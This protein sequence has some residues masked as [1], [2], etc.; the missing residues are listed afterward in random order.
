MSSSDHIAVIFDFDGTL[1]PD[2]VTKLLTAHKIDP[3]KFWLQE[4]RALTDQGYDQV[5][6]YL[7]LILRNIGAGKPLGELTNADLRKFG[8][9]LGFYSCLPRL[10]NDLRAIAKKHTD[11]DVE[12]YVIS[13]GL[14]DII[15]GSKIIR[16]YFR[17]TYGCQLAGDKEDGVLKYIKRAITFTEK[18]R[19]LF[20]INKGIDPSRSLRNSDSVN[21]DIPYEKRRIPFSNMIYIGDGLTDIPCF[22]LVMK[23]LGYHEGGHAFGIF[24]PADEKSARIALEKLLETRRVASTHAHKYGKKDELGSLLRATVKTLCS[25]I[26]SK[27]E[28]PY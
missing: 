14:Q 24:D 5:H 1:V 12:Y 16:K 27:R 20:E 2:S 17:A 3:R 15:D 19:Y 7:N 23:G 4:V 21:K 28:Q 22:S 25:K 13:S 11:I 8:S 10:F 6:A 9:G 26:D 18:T